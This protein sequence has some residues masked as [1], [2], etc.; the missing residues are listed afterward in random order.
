VNVVIHRIRLHGGTPPELF[1][2]WV[3]EVDYA[4]CPLLPSVESFTVQ[5]I[6]DRPGEYFEV[7][8]VRSEAEFAA[9]M[10]SPV[11]HSLEDAF[12]RLATV[13]DALTGE[14]IEPGYRAR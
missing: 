4:A 6:P 5:R 1:E 8:E 11:F 14:R 12:G 3:R 10:G 13:V 9:D 7:I 2:R